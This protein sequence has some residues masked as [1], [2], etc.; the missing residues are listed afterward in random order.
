M[1]NTLAIFVSALAFTSVQAIDIET[2]YDYHYAD[3][4]GQLDLTAELPISA[5]SGNALIQLLKKDNGIMDLLE[6]GAK[7]NT[8][9]D[10]IF[11]KKNNIDA[12]Y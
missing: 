8:I 6:N 4:F 12:G 7:P 9:Q 10:T 2:N 1:R 5:E 11:K 3:E